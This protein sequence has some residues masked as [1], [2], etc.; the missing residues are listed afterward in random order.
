MSK[1]HI[2]I[3][4]VTLLSIKHN[5]HQKDS[6][7]ED[8]ILCMLNLTVIEKKSVW[9][10][11]HIVLFQQQTKRN[12]SKSHIIINKVTLLSIKHAEGVKVV[13][14]KNANTA[15]LWL[16]NNI[17]DPAVSEVGFDIEWKPQFV[18]KKKG[19]TENKTAVIQLSV[20][21]SCLVLHIFRMKSLPP[22]LHIVLSDKNILKVGSGINGDVIKLLNDTGMFCNGRVDTQECAKAVGIYEHVG[23]KH[24][25]RQVLKID[26]DKPKSVS[27]SNWEYYPLKAKQIHYAALDAWVSLKLFL[28]LREK[29][30]PGND[31]KVFSSHVTVQYG[32]QALRRKKGASKLKS[33]FKDLKAKESQESVDEDS[34][35]DQESVS[36]SSQTTVLQEGSETMSSHSSKSGISQSTSNDVASDDT[37][38]A[39]TALLIGKGKVSKPFTCP[40]LCRKAKFTTEEALQDHIKSKHVTCTVC[41]QVF[42]SKISAK[43]KK[44]HP[45]GYAKTSTPSIY[46]P[47]TG[48]YI[49]PVQHCRFLKFASQETLQE[50]IDSKHVTCKICGQVYRSKIS[51]KHKKLHGTNGLCVG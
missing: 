2:I 23:L 7:Q 11:I 6:S 43:H 44:K 38:S 17:I 9:Q 4:K 26:I 49:C 14:T 42:R 12:M 34:R 50:H 5:K 3:N 45:D 35:E 22:S 31:L 47:K 21:T 37:I 19:G 10:I 29:I 15:E 39:A 32:D 13:Y 28:K 30:D 1:S 8:Q 48:Q 46:C 33:I 36:S 25:A 18:P 16:K 41:G 20:K 40:M 51:Q 24:L 27:M